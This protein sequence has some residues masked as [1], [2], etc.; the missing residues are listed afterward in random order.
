MDLHWIRDNHSTI[1]THPEIGRFTITPLQPT[2]QV[3]DRWWLQYPRTTGPE[4][5]TTSTAAAGE[6]TATPHSRGPATPH[7]SVPVKPARGSHPPPPPPPVLAE[8]TAAQEE[9][10]VMDED[11]TNVEPPAASKGKGKAKESGMLK[12]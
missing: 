3:A 5:P 6:S 12:F 4:V 2:P 8:E 7:G 10:D 9:E 11:T 1:H